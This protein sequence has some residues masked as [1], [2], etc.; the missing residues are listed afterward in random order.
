MVSPINNKISCTSFNLC[1]KTK[2]KGKRMKQDKEIVKLFKKVK[3]CRKCYP[4]ELC[5]PLPDPKNGYKNVKVMFINER[6]GRIGA[7][8]S[9]YISFD[10][11]DP[12]A[13]WFKYCFSLTNLSRK[14]IFTTNACLCYPK[15]E[16]YN[17]TTPKTQIIKNCQ[18]WL[19]L[20]IE[21]MK[22]K[23][24]VTLGNSALKAIKLRFK[25]Q[26]SKE[27]KR[28]KLKNNI[29]TVVKTTNPWIYPIYHTSL[30]ARITRKNNQQKKD[31][32]K[33]RTILKELK[34]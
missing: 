18:D 23:L 13:K 34:K 5:V 2:E 24:I 3:K 32:E 1:V 26:N 15:K 12:S 29:G 21:I 28:F 16:G 4:H 17:D 33:I 22:P 31:W 25:D 30:R 20:Q 9:N 7:G 19:E 14:E 8:G 27:L 6:P 10:N 11:N